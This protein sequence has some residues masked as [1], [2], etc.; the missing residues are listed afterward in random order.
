MPY[1]GL[2]C[3]VHVSL[4]VQGA[5]QVPATPPEDWGNPWDAQDWDPASDLTEQ[6]IEQIAYQAE[7]DF[8]NV[9]GEDTPR[10]KWITPLLDFKSVSGAID[11]DQGE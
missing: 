11:P 8:R 7:E 9:P 10:D 3:F 6:Q 5:M 4:Q 2:V 1:T